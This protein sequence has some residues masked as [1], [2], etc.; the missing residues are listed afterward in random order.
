MSLSRRGVLTPPPTNVV[1]GLSRDHAGITAAWGTSVIAWHVRFGRGCPGSL[2][3]LLSAPVGT[4]ITVRRNEGE[5]RT[6][7]ITERRTV[8]KGRYDV[9]WFRQHGPHRLAL[10]SCAD[11]EGGTFR[12]NVVI[13]ADE[14]PVADG[15]AVATS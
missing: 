15:P 5:P 12:K 14:V 4:E 8:P 9:E 10:F 6:Y 3:D 11:P 13:L 2:N 1:A 7:R